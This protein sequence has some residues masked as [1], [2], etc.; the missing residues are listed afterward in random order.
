MLNVIYL[1]RLPL[2]RTALLIAHLYD[3]FTTLSHAHHGSC[4]RDVS[5]SHYEP[6]FG[7]FLKCFNSPPALWSGY[8]CSSFACLWY[9]HVTYHGRR[10]FREKSFS[11]YITYR[12]N[13]HARSK[14][15][16]KSQHIEF[17]VLWCHSIHS[18]VFCRLWNCVGLTSCASSLSYHAIA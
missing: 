10:H 9:T 12:R 7:L 6:K 17:L 15:V 14:R 16:Y 3:V 2:A 5:Y 4:D 13:I 18:Y 8:G 1:E 11:L